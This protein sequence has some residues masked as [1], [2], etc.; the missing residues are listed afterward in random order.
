MPPARPL[1]ALCRHEHAHPRPTRATRTSSSALRRV[2]PRGRGDPRRRDRGAAARATPAASATTA[3][4]WTAATPDEM[5]DQLFARARRGG[6]DA[7]AAL[8]VAASL[9]DRASFGRVRDGLAALAA[10]GSPLA[11]E[12]RWLGLRLL[13]S[14]A[15]RRLAR[16]RARSPYDA[17][18]DADGLVKS[19]AILGPFQDT[20]GGLMRREGPEAA[21]RA[22]ERHARAL[23]VGR[24]RR[25]LAPRRSPPRS[26]PRGVPLDL[27]IHPRA[28]SCTYP[29]LARHRPRGARPV[30][31]HVGATG[32]V[33]VIWD[34]ADVAASDD[35]H[36]HL[37]AR[38][39]RGAHR[40]HRGR[41]P[42][43]REGVHRRGRGR[44]PRA[45]PLHRRAE[46]A[47]RRSPRRRISASSASP[48][49]RARRRATAEAPRPAARR[50]ARARPGRPGKR[51]VKAAQ[52]PAPGSAPRR[53]SRGRRRRRA[54]QGR[55]PEEGRAARRDAPA[56]AAQRP[57]HI[58]P[59]PGRHRPAHGAREGARR[60]RRAHDRA[61]ARRRGGAHARRRRRRAL[62]ARARP[63]RSRRPRAADVTPGRA[64]HG[65]VDLALRRQ[66]QRVAEPRARPRQAAARRRHRG[67]RAAP[68][69]RG[70]PRLALRRLGRRLVARG[71]ARLRHRPGGRRS[72]GR[73]SRSS[74]AA[75]G[76]GRSALDELLGIEA[77]AA[78]QDPDR[79]ALRAVRPLA[80]RSPSCTSAWRGAS[81]RSMADGRGPA[82]VDAFRSE[83]AAAM[84]EAAAESLAEQTSVDEP[85]PR[86]PRA[87][88][89][90]AAT[91]GRARSSTSPRSSRPTAPAAFSGLAAAREAIAADEARAGKPPSEPP[92]RAPEPASRA[93]TTSSRAT[94]CSRP[95][96]PTAA[97]P[98][99]RAAAATAPPSRTRRTSSS[100]RSSSRRRARTR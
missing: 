75:T 27:Y 52:P 91:P 8:V 97:P 41:S 99:R 12:A 94:R 35:V 33:R 40:R 39:D 92:A 32:A 93:P 57:R 98:A 85:P 70:A 72:S 79:R 96:S 15:R 78:G 50:D 64:R 67:L 11:D 4:R 47:A 23:R 95:R 5:V 77:R 54:G 55:A 76:F 81:S 84:E 69:G 60:R 82:Y 16:H 18:P 10:S 43:R 90:P 45:P 13:P 28:E 20:G 58:V 29:R 7:L 34:G 83:G 46:P 88:S 14:P 3:A 1:H 89:T 62:A 38:P 74:S 100:P 68:P 2:G 31:L 71:A 48:R 73:W 42:R 22:L 26:P 19:F 37:V 24:L 30:V 49:R 59:P 65:R 25:R 9:D 63:A 53:P 6:D 87:C 56:V 17:P 80:Q 21:R 51:G 86:S 61:G 44:G 36:A 66:P